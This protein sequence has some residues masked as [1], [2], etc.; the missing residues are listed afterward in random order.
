[1][2][3]EAAAEKQGR[4]VGYRL[5]FWLV[6]ALFVT[7]VF[8]LL[9]LLTGGSAYLYHLLLGWL[10]FLPRAPQSLTLDGTNWLA[11]LGLFTVA[12][13]LSVIW[14]W[15]R[16]STL[17]DELR[18]VGHAP[19]RLFLF[20]AGFAGLV[21]LIAFAV[22]GIFH[23]TKIAF[24]AGEP[25]RV[26]SDGNGS[27]YAAIITLYSEAKMKEGVSTPEDL[28]KQTDMKRRME[29]FRV[30]ML[31]DERGFFQGLV[32]FRKPGLSGRDP[33]LI[34][35][36]PEKLYYPRNKLHRIQEVYG[37]RLRPIW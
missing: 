14:L 34:R 35:D 25:F 28:V 26:A 27:S 5:L 12:L 30:L 2:S 1:M 24:T 10:H 37:H 31:V 9:H 4:H 23:T 33:I 20:A 19:R 29:N 6:V 15:R 18:L 22:V 32:V 7:P 8:L 36:G 16:R 17:S 11:W 13:A 3:E 21:C